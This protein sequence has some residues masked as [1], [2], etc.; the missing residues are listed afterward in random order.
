MRK[1]MKQ[2]IELHRLLSEK[3]VVAIDEIA[4]QLRMI[5]NPNSVHSEHEVDASID[6]AAAALQNFRARTLLPAAE[7]LAE[8]I[9]VRKA[10]P[11]GNGGGRFYWRMR[12]QTKHD[13][14]GKWN[15]PY[16]SACVDD[17][18]KNVGTLKHAR[19]RAAE[20]ILRGHRVIEILPPDYDPVQQREQERQ[21]NVSKMQ[22]DGMTVRQR[23]KK[24]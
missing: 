10:A 1:S 11:S 21:R 15:E 3:D 6:C 23:E 16:L 7:R 18:V 2:A 20:A 17:P 19:K 4:L 8:M 14:T 22:P 12:A 5:T 9:P 13:E 24:H